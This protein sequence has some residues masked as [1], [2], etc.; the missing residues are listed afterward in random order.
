MLPYTAFKKGVH[1]I[2]DQQGNYTFYIHPW[3][4]DHEQPRMQG[5][6]W[7]LRLRHYLNLDKTKG[8][9]NRLISE[10]SF[11]PIKSALKLAPMLK[12]E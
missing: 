9:F 5:I 1:K 6:S 10:F 7:Q 3:E 8:R 11:E 12:S 4:F 2:V